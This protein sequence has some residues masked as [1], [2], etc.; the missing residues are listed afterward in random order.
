MPEKARKSQFMRDNAV[1]MAGTVLGGLL[2]YAFH[3]V[4]SR[5]VSVSQYGELQSLLSILVIF[6]VFNSALSFFTVKYTSVFFAN[7]DYGANSQFIGYLAKKVSRHT[8]GFLLILLI[9]SPI[10]ARLLHFSSILGFFVVSLATYFSTVA[11]IYSEILRGW[12]KFFLTSVVGVAAAL[13]KFVSGAGFAYALHKASA[14]S[15][16]FLASALVGWYLARYYSRKNIIEKGEKQTAST[17]KEKYFSE[18]NMRKSAMNIFFFSLALIL[19]SNLDVILVKYFSSSETT[20][21]FGAFALLGKIILWLNLAVVGVMLPGACADGHAGRRPG[22]K[23]LL[24]SYGLMSLIGIAAV[25]VYFIAPDIV[26]QIFFGKKYVFDTGILWLF[27]V[28]SY[29]LSLLTLEANL[30]FAKHDFRVVYFLAATVIFMVAGVARYHSSLKDVVLALTVSYLFGYLF[31][32]VLNLS[33][34]R[35]RLKAQ[36][37]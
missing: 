17:W 3:F 37:P 34:E 22:K 12:H 31:V 16:S 21:Y 20:G 2:G 13:M 1:F 35:K 25:L 18:T 10:L 9:A 7:G 8:L 33:Q 36:T 30:S 19:V 5:E 4:V 28:M 23:S 11:I 6:G 26:V 15:L 29:L 14:V 32:V 24:K 27:G